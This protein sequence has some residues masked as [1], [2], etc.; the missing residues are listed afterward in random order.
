MPRTAPAVTGAA[1]AALVSFRF[2]DANQNIVSWSIRTTVALAT[3]ANVEAVAAALATASN[4]SLWGVVI[5]SA[6]ETVP[7][8]VNAVDA[9]YSSGYDNVVELFKDI[10][11][12]AAQD[13]FIP[14][15]IDALM[16]TGTTQVD[17]ANTDFIAFSNAV[18][19]LLP[20]AYVPVSARLSERRK[21]YSRV[22]I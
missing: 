14:A 3:G 10:A 19:T 21:T 12:G 16:N 1:T 20:A 7:N 13:A 17:L 15:P 18:N 6:W 4:A 5:S 8:A 2:I 22:R 11:S 9:P